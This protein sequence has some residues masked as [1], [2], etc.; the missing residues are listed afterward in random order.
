MGGFEKLDT[1]FRKLWSANANSPERMLHLFVTRELSLRRL[2]AALDFVSFRDFAVNDQKYSLHFK[3]AVLESA[4]GKPVS[5]AGNR[6]RDCAH[7]RTPHAR[8]V[9]MGLL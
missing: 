4:F 3:A 8:N 9:C 1:A 5:S 7:I 2:G 6:Q